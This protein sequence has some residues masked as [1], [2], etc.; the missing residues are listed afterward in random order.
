MKKFKHD[1]F[2]LETKTVDKVNYTITALP[3]YLVLHMKRFTQNNF[4]LE[5]N[6]TI[7]TFPT[8]GLD[9]MSCK[10]VDT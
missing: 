2:T 4:F 10:L 8:T 3:Q 5:K 9:L 7:V 6:P 1:E